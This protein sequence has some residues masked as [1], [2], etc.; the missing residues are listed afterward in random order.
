MGGGDDEGSA[1]SAGGGG[2]SHRSSQ[3][4]TFQLALVINHIFAQLHGYAFYLE[5]PCKQTTKGPL[6]LQSSQPA[7]P[8]QTLGNALTGR[9]VSHRRRRRAVDQVRLRAPAPNAPRR[10][11][12]QAPPL[13]QTGDGVSRSLR[14]PSAGPLPASACGLDEARGHSLLCASARVRAV[15]RLGRLRDSGVA[16]SRAAH[17]AATHAARRPPPEMARSRGRVPAPEAARR[18]SRWAGQLWG[19]ALRWAVYGRPRRDALDR[20]LDL[21]VSRAASRDL[22][23]AV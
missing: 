18:R 21:A 5:A 13:P 22:H 10:L 15:P 19:A 9:R 14:V 17:H 4:G 12:T 8:S 7:N 1:G 11:L 2:A 20:G 3:V 6:L 16:A 23:V